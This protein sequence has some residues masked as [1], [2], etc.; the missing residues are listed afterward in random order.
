MK[1]GL[2]INCVFIYCL[3]ATCQINERPFSMACSLRGMSL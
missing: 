1:R 3:T 2:F